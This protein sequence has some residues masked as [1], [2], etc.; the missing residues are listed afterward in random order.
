M[1][2]R[3]AVQVGTCYC[4]TP[5]YLW[6][7]NPECDDYYYPMCP[8]C[9]LAYEEAMRPQTNFAIGWLLTKLLRPNRRHI[10]TRGFDPYAG[11]AWSF[12]LCGVNV[13]INTVISA[14]VSVGRWDIHDAFH[15]NM[16]AFGDW[17]PDE[18][19]R[20]NSGVEL[21]VFAIGMWLFAQFENF[22]E[23]KQQL[24]TDYDFQDFGP[25]DYM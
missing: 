17:W 16:N 14:T 24:G 3:K 25:A 19:L 2:E 5:V 15:R 22:Y 8:A 10:V 7:D 1:E 6:S 13:E 4:G 23:Y 9:E 21:A 20:R 11:E 18:G 12:R